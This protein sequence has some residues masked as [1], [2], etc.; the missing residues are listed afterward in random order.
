MKD[1]NMEK[2]SNSIKK[3]HMGVMAFKI[4]SRL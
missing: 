3:I 1:L 2:N 4:V